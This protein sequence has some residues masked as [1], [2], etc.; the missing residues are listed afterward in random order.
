MLLLNSCPFCLSD[1]RSKS[2]RRRRVDGKR[3]ARD[4]YKGAAADVD[5]D[6][7]LVAEA[8]EGDEEDCKEY[9]QRRKSEQDSRY[10]KL[11]V[12]L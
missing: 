7:A 1:Q 4:T 11:G 3:N 2:G 9:E 5:V 10:Q 6:H 12:S 8:K